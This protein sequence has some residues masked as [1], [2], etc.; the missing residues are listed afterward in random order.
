MS[1]ATL[2]ITS[3][4]RPDQGD[5]NAVLIQEYTVAGPESCYREIRELARG[6][7]R[8]TVT[9]SLVASLE[10][11][12]FNY[13]EPPFILLACSN[14]DHDELLEAINTKLSSPR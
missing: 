14:E 12:D 7:W 9:Q 10:E 1:R 11:L 8:R 5:Q 6:P 2:V 13:K 3:I 4:C